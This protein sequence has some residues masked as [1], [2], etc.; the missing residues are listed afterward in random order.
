[1]EEALG[2]HMSAYSAAVTESEQDT[3]VVFILQ[4]YESID[5][6]FRKQDPWKQARICLLYSQDLSTQQ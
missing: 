1:M 2:P 5:T 3:H 4:A 6:D